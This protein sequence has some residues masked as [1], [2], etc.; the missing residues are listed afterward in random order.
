[1]PPMPL[2]LASVIAQVD[3]S[4]HTIMALDFMFADDHEKEL[5]E[6]L[7]EFKPDL[8]AI[9]IRN[10][11][12]Q[13]SLHTEYLLP[14]A[15]KAIDICRAD[16]DATIVVGGGAVTVSPVAIL[17]YLGADFA[18]DGEG[19]IVFN[20]LVDRLER[21]A[22][23]SDLPGLVWRD[24]GGVKA[25]PR[26]Y[27]HD[28][29]SLRPPRRDLF[30]NERYAAEGGFANIV[31]KQ[32]CGFNCLYC[33]GPS[34]MG[35]KWRKRSPE[36]IVDELET[37]H[38]E[39]GVNV[40]FFTDTIF[41]FPIDH[42]KEVCREIIR[43]KPGV[44][45]V[46]TVSPAYLDK[47]MIALMQEAGCN[48]VSLGCDSCSEKMLKILRKGFT[49]EQL[50]TATELLEEAGLNYILS[51]LIGAPGEDRETVE[52]TVEFLEK[53]SPFMLDFCVGIRLMPGTDLVDIAIKEGVISADDP[54]MEPRFYVAPEIID[55]IED[56]LAEV[57]APHPNWTLAHIE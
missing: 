43:R 8:I 56:Y 16:S 1:M 24:D 2:G 40:S 23:Y 53:R 39:Y 6:A 30:D 57:C 54:L 47:E 21:K 12:N 5:K 4:R 9:S 36:K 13:S 33:D 44:F 45:W 14:D 49:K 22:D 28:L 25:N 29:D 42:C 17:E 19:E 37:M 11:D 10:L 34:V 15:K 51:L 52:E 20:E 3:E 31:I 48:A 7:A 26:E 38:N 27:I 50:R 32:G 46:A 41:N 18:V 55:W 35:R